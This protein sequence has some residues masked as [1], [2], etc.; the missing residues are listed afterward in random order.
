M[1]KKLKNLFSSKPTKAEV[2]PIEPSKKILEKPNET[3]EESKFRV[4]MNKKLRKS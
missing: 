1:W 3:L 4:R 2:E